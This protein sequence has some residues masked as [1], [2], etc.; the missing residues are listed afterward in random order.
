MNKS[1]ANDTALC[2]SKTKYSGFMYIDRF[3][4]TQKYTYPQISVSEMEM[5]FDWNRSLKKYERYCP[6]EKLDFSCITSKKTDDPL[7]T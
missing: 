6:E 3:R 2:F 4:L 7:N 1:R 5:D